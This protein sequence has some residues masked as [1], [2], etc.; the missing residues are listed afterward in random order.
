MAIKFIEDKKLFRLDAG[1][2]TY[3][4]QKGKVAAVV[5]KNSIEKSGKS[6]E[7]IFFEITEGGADNEPGSSA[8]ESEVQG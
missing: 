6:L 5:E 1:D 3:I 2:T 8:P 4:M 7:D